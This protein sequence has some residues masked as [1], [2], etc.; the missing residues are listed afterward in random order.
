MTN[1]KILYVDIHQEIKLSKEGEIFISVFVCDD[2][3]TL[4]IEYDV[5]YCQDSWINFPSHQF[6][7]YEYGDM[8]FL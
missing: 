2:P 1:K 5:L 7:T 3:N 4:V 8:I 6:I